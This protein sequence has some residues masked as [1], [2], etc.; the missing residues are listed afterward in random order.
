MEVEQTQPIIP[1]DEGLSW[2]FFRVWND[3][4]LKDRPQRTDLRNHIWASELGGAYIDRYLKMK[5]VPYTNPPNARSLRKFQAGD[6]WEWIVQLIL[7]RAGILIDTQEHL[8]F[9][10]PEL[11]EVTGKLDFLAGGKP[12]WEKAKSEVKSIGLPELIEEASVAIIENLQV[13]YGDDLKTIVLEVKSCSTMMFD[14][15]ER[16]GKA[17]PHHKLQLFHYLKAKNLPEGHIVYICKDDC[18]MMEIGVLNVPSVE[19]EYKA[20]ILKMT[21]FV[22]NNVEPEVEKEVLFDFDSIRFTKNWKVEYSPYLTKL[23][24]HSEPEAFREM[25]DSKVAQF[26]R[27]LKRVATE[28]KMTPLNLQVIEEIR[29]Y[30]PNYLEIV[31]LAKQKAAEAVEDS[32]ESEA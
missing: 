8:S 26:N 3:S 12:D 16:T 31:D 6:I 2:S 1:I 11:L 9:Q 23:Y 7:K 18:R 19:E 24:G 21:Q 27:T 30:F 14:K 32:V 29:A 22:Q 15:Y 28:Q 10:Y 5:G 20:D 4:L 25:W 17:N 13:K